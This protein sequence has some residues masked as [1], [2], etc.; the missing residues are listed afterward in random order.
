MYAIRSYYV[1]TPVVTVLPQTKLRDA[2]EQMHKFDIS[3]LVIVDKARPVITS[4]SIHYTKLYEVHNSML[5]HVSR[6]MRWQD[7]IAELVSNQFIYYRRGID[8]ND[9]TIINRITS[10]NVCYTKLLRL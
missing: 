2:A 10:Y 5:I 1:V 9:H 4:Y 3:A 8:Q 7:H 6:F